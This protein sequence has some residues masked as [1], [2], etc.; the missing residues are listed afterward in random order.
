MYEL[1]TNFLGPPLPPPYPRLLHCIFILCDVTLK[2]CGTAVAI[3]EYCVLTAYHNIA[4]DPL[5]PTRSHI[6]SWRIVN[7]L[8]RNSDGSVQTIDNFV[9]IAVTVHKYSYNA[10]WVIL[11][12]DVGS[13]NPNDVV[14]ICPAAE[15]PTYGE[16]PNVKIYQCAV[17]LFNTG[18]VNAIRPTSLEVKMGFCSSHKVF[19]Q[20]GL[21]GGSSGAVYVISDYRHI[22]FGKAF[23]MHCESINAARTISD[24]EDEGIIIDPDA[25]VEEVSDSCVNSHAS[26]VEGILISKYKTLLENIF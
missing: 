1:L 6:P 17:E 13:F 3:S 9:P 22:G 10:D 4:N 15:I 19:L 24:I 5:K 14:P 2:A 16:E 21:F 8:E 12:R 23:G 18:F 7:G 20:A 11:K 26:F 25:I